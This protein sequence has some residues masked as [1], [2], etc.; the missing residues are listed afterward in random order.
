MIKLNTPYTHIDCAIAI[1][2]TL[3]IEIASWT[4]C[5]D[6]TTY[7]IEDFVVDENGAKKLINSRHKRIYNA[8]YNQLEDYIAHSNSFEGM[9]KIERDWAKARIGLL[10]FVKNDFI[11]DGVHTIYNKLP[12]NWVFS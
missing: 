11:A 8:E 12:E 2:G 4:T 7:A 10:Y 5:P 3:Q 6:A 1:T 9:T